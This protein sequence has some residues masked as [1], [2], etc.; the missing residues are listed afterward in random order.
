[1]LR[2]AEQDALIEQRLVLALGEAREPLMMRD[3]FTTHNADELAGQRYDDIYEFFWAVSLSQLAV[4]M[5]EEFDAVRAHR[6]MGAGSSWFEF[7]QQVRDSG[8][9]LLGFLVA[10]PEQLDV[11]LNMNQRP[12]SGV[13][14]LLDGLGPT[15]LDEHIVRLRLAIKDSRRSWYSRENQH[16]PG[17]NPHGAMMLESMSEI[18][19]AIADGDA[20][21]ELLNSWALGQWA[22]RAQHS[23]IED[24]TEL[25]QG[26]Y[27]A[28]VLQGNWDNA[29]AVVFRQALDDWMVFTR[30]PP[31]VL[32]THVMGVTEFED[33][34]FDASNPEFSLWKMHEAIS[35][36]M[37]DY[38]FNNR[39]KT[40]AELRPAIA[41]LLSLP[42]TELEVVAALTSSSGQ[43]LDLE[44]VLDSLT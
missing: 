22:L 13:S 23:H 40:I 30:T 34:W 41:R 32:L 28:N 33:W 27:L 6:F 17:L 7:A 11:L 2:S 39:D 42:R 36:T 18:V 38:M 20:P 37:D 24:L 3:E 9:S 14:T 12:S 44:A 43:G 25:P 26:Q 5:P 29:P 8:L 4:T 15:S 31:K 16:M 35:S 1:M 19:V 10:N 21:L